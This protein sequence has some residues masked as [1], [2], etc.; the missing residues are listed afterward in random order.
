MTEQ[1]A[2]LTEE[3]SVA[4]GNDYDCDTCGYT[5]NSARF[6][7]DWDDDGSGTWMFT[8]RVG[9]YGGEHVS[10]TDPDAL[11]TLEELF[12][13]CREYPDWSDSDEQTIRD[14]LSTLAPAPGE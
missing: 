10:S 5:W 3:Y 4:L 2:R 12:A 8:V 9:C 11:A 6:D 7:P 14:H 1:P 13:M